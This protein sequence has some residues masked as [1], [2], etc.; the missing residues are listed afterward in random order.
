MGGFADVLGHVAA[1]YQDASQK[2]QTRQFTDEQN[3]RA[4]FSDLLG[5]LVTDDSAHPATRQNAAQILF[6]IQHQPWNKPVKLDVNRLLAPPPPPG[7][8]GPKPSAVTQAMQGQ[9]A[10]SPQQGAAAASPA[11]AQPPAPPQG[12]FYSPDEL[13][14]QKAS[15][16]GKVAGST[17]TAQFGARSKALEGMD[18][19][20]EQKAG[21][22]L[23]VPGMA[24]MSGA[25]GAGDTMPVSVAAQQGLPVPD[26]A[27][28]NGWV[29]VQRNKMGHIVGVFPTA[30][31]AAYA[32][33]EHQGFTY[34]TQADG[35]IVA[36]PVTTTSQKQS[37]A[38][39]KPA[40]QQPQPP[41]SATMP[42]PAAPAK[43]KASIGTGGTRVGMQKPPQAIMIAP[44]SAP[45]ENARA[46]AVRP[47]SSV[48]LGSITP[49]GLSSSNVPTAS[50]RSRSEFA[51]GLIPGVDRGMTYIQ[52]IDPKKLGWLKGRYNEL[53]AGK[54]GGG[55]DDDPDI[56]RLRTNIGLIQTGMMVP[57]VG[58]R[59]GTQLIAK[60]KDM[61]DS[62]KASPAQLTASLGEMR[63]FLVTYAHEGEIK[64]WGNKSVDDL[65]DIPSNGPI[66]P[67]PKKKFDWHAHPTIQGAGR[68]SG[69]F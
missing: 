22:T 20:P 44:P 38:G 11:L 5:K 65:S 28:P 2:E 48:P 9:A 57:H 50:T 8:Q 67:Q 53:I 64:G 37:P 7:E 31:P 23:G 36:V 62:G 21:F 27:D 4:Q 30:Q 52:Q 34:Q 63:K 46:I 42:T 16:A 55:L 19:P 26:E 17:M 24:A 45:G 61:I 41:G 12:L 1:G 14:E 32:P 18:I 40:L 68:G 56:S 6:E 47:G 58:A 39:S 29:R 59:G 60:F 15:A 49:G 3:K 66:G 43:P 54:L 10:P 33:T 69:T 13:A 25:Y 51:T 35:S